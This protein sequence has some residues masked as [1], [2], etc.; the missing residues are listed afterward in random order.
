MGPLPPGTPPKAASAST[1]GG[2]PTAAAALPCS[3]C[4]ARCRPANPWPPAPQDA[5]ILILD[6]ATSSLDAEN[7]RLVQAAIEKLMEGR[8]V[9]VIA[10]RLSTVQN[11]DQAGARLPPPGPCAPCAALSESDGEACCN[12]AQHSRV[13][14]DVPGRWR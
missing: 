6:E 11:A 1:A 8:T 5:P 2:R 13:H 4:T 3:G 14:A 12:Y 7:E 9:M 10:H